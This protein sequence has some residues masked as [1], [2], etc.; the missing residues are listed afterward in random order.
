MSKAIVA[1]IWE[2][3]LWYC[4]SREKDSKGKG[5]DCMG[6]EFDKEFTSWDTKWSRIVET[7][8]KRDKEEDIPEGKSYLGGLVL[9]VNHGWGVRVVFMVDWTK[10]GEF[11]L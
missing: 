10:D 2:P 9:K 11:D 4:D 7:K 8:F 5:T 6:V 1:F 3:K